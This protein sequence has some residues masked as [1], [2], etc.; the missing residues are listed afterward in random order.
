MRDRTRLDDARRIAGRL[1]VEWRRDPRVYAEDLLE[2]S[3]EAD[4]LH[5]DARR[6]LREL[7]FGCLHGLGRYEFILRRHARNTKRVPGGAW[8]SVM[9]GLHELSSMRTPT[10][11]AVDQAVTA[12]RALGA[13][14]AARFVNGV[15]RAALREGLDAGIPT[16][17]ADPRGHAEIALSH[18][19]WLVDRWAAS[20]GDAEMLELCRW[21]NRRPDLVLRARPGERSALLGECER[22]GWE[23]EPCRSGDGL[24]LV[25]RVPAPLILHELG[26]RCAVQDEAAQLVAPL[27]AALQPTTV[28]D[29]CAAPGGKTVHLAQ[30]LPEAQ[31]LAVDRSQARVERIRENAE[32]LGLANVRPRVGDGTAL[33]VADTSFVEVDAVLVDAP[34]TGTGVLARRHDLRWRRKPSDLPRLV[35]LQRRLLGA[36]LDLVRP[37]GTVVYATCSL[38]PEEN[39]GVVDAILAAR[40]D[41]EEIGVDKEAD[42]MFLRDGR[43]QTWP[44]RHGCDGAFAARLRRKSGT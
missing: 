3:T 14:H 13:P 11:A 32:R 44:Q 7:L 27:L 18:P 33:A 41:V 37:G 2:A 35:D 30:L 42:V 29:L 40:D 34:C 21:N 1:L 4:A 25:T 26:D 5:P 15:L 38:E 24:R 20:L 8:A 9:L 16:A 17:D 12:C 6:R 22:L 10:H 43:L 23:A 39:D 31:I 28:V 19:R 36:A